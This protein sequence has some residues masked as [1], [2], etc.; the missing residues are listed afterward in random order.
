MYLCCSVRHSF[1]VE[2]ALEGRAKAG[3]LESFRK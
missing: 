2:V 3:W 1:T